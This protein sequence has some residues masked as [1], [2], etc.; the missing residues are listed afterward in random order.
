VPIDPS[1]V[2]PRNPGLSHAARARSWFRR[3]WFSIL[4]VLVSGLGFVVGLASG[5]TVRYQRMPPSAKQSD[6]PDDLALQLGRQGTDLV[7]RWNRRAEAIRRAKGGLL[8]IW[9]G[10]SLPQHHTLDANELRTLSVSYSPASDHVVFRLAVFGH[11]SQNVAERVLEF[12]AL[13]SSV[14]PDDSTPKS[15]IERR[16]GK[17]RAGEQPMTVSARCCADGTGVGTARPTGWVRSS[18]R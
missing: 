15:R 18:V 8:S 11:D 12:T 5:R 6:S 3:P 9:D 1:A 7:V 4:A 16:V 10:D 14:S 13:R 2:L 17:L